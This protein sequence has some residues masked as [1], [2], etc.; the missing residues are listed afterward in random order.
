MTNRNRSSN[1]YKDNSKE[2][3][4]ITHSL[5]ITLP[6]MEIVKFGK[7]NQ[8]PAHLSRVTILYLY[9]DSKTNQIIVDH[10]SNYG[11]RSPEVMNTY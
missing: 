10:M 1:H 6:D 8:T 9:T 11:S 3:L 2:S 7:D 5:Q 4:E